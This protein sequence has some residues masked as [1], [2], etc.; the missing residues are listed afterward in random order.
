MSRPTLLAAAI[1]SASCVFVPDSRAQQV[2]FSKDVQ[3]I[4]N[5]NC[6]LC[7]KGANAPAGLQL[8]SATGVLRGGASGKVVVPGNS[9]DSVLAQRITDSSGNQMPP[10]APLPANV[11]KIITDWIDQGAKA[12]VSPAE[13]TRTAPRKE[14]GDAP[15]IASVTNAAQER[16]ML[17]YYCVVCHT[18]P[19]APDGLQLDRIDPANVAKDAEKWEKVVRKLRAGMMPPAGNARPAASAY[20]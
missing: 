11:I 5:S 10:S 2:D 18:G 1:F 8:D 7:H 16:V 3:P 19:D 4:F 13:L 14:R 9:K 17:D 12:D 20:E 6:T 15:Q